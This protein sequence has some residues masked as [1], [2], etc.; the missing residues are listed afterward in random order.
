MPD[1]FQFYAG[2][3]GLPAPGKGA[4]ESLESSADTYKELKAMKG[5]RKILSNFAVT[6][7][8]WKGKRWNTVEHAFQAAKFETLAPELFDSFSLTSDSELSKAGGDAARSERKAL[9][10]TS[11]QKAEW[12]VRS[13]SVMRELWEAKFSQSEEARRVLLLTENAQLWHAAPRVA[14]VRWEELEAIREK[15]R[16][17]PAVVQRNA[18]ATPEM[19]DA[20]K[21]KKKAATGKKSKKAADEGVPEGV[22]VNGEEA[23]A[24]PLDLP[25]PDLETPERQESAIRFCPVCRYYLYVEANTGQ[26]ESLYR[27]C[28]NCGYRKEDEHGGVVTEMAI[29]EKAAEGYKILLNEFT[30]RD[31]RL[32]H[33]KNDVKCPDPACDSNHGKADPD[34]IYI[35]YD[36]INMLYLYIC[37]ICGHQWRSRR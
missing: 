19:A 7:F 11:A 1:I 6:P 22:V 35:K 15:L 5:W 23:N 27:F 31:P 2:S 37:D 34:V 28:R 32:P 30:R 3:A 12:D 20:P 8:T 16:E 14:K 21:T 24:P 10:F 25:P 33:I 29:Q 13:S 36:P 4:G 9:V 17:A 18:E 26:T